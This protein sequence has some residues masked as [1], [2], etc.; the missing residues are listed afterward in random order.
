MSVSYRLMDTT[1]L[2]GN[3]Q[4]ELSQAWDGGNYK[5][6]G[7]AIRV[8]KGTGNVGFKVK[9]THAATLDND[10][11]LDLLDKDGNP[12]ELILSASGGA[13]FECTGFLRYVR[14]VTFGWTSGDAVAVIDLM[15][16][17]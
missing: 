4:Q 5:Q 16:K 7:V 15:G 13:Y 12:V 9:V 10:A 1:V 11:F 17:E 3:Q 6:L 8:P 2:T 14:F